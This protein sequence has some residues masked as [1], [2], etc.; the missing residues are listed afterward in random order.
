LAKA[1]KGSAGFDK[2]FHGKIKVNDGFIF[3]S[4]S[5]QYELGEILDEMVLLI[6][7]YDLYSNTRT[8]PVDSITGFGSN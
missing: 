2:C 7:D 4:A 5:D 6:L 8:N 3:V 1:G